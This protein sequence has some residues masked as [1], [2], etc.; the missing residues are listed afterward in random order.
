MG[1][2]VALSGTSG[3]ALG[4]GAVQVKFYR[5]TTATGRV[6]STGPRRA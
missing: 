2:D 4:D 1:L 5:G 3:A 6:A